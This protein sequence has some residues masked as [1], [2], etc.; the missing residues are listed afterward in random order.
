[1]PIRSTFTIFTQF[2]L[3]PSVAPGSLAAEGGGQG[4]GNDNGNNALVAMR[5]TA[6]G[7]FA[8]Q[9]GTT[10]TSAAAASFQVNVV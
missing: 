6:G 9:L 1:L 4:S 5:A 2:S 10:I 7:S 8:L 3:A